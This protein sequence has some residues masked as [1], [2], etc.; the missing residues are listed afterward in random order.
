[1]TQ[2]LTRKTPK[3]TR[4]Q[5]IKKMFFPQ[6]S[7]QRKNINAVIQKKQEN[8]LRNINRNI[9]RKKKQLKQHKHKMSKN[10]LASKR[11]YYN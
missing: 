8:I 10:E 4:Q 11:I 1:M 6:I 2:Q 3:L 5:E 7:M 9:S